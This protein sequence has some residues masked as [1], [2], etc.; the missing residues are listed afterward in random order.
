MPLNGRWPSG[1]LATGARS[2]QHVRP[3]P[4]K[5]EQKKKLVALRLGSLGTSQKP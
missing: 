4:A 5:G 1:P 3:L 2:M